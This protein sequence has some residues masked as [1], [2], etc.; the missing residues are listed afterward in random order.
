MWG[1][2]SNFPTE[3]RPLASGY[4]PLTKDALNAK[5]IIR[6]EGCACA[7]EGR[8]KVKHPRGTSLRK[9]AVR[10]LRSRGQNRGQSLTPAVTITDILR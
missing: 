10:K 2:T 5:I 9:G 6:A 4:G 3:F 8:F 1:V 7:P